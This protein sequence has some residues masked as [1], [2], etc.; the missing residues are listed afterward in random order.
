MPRRTKK[1]LEK[2]L[3]E[4]GKIYK[5]YQK[6]FDEGTYRIKNSGIY[7]LME[8]IYFEPNQDNDW[9]PKKSQDQ[10]SHSAYNLGFFAAITVECKNVVIDLD[11]KSLQQSRVF[12]LQQRFYSNIELANTPFIKGQGP[13]NFGALTGSAEHCVIKNGYLGLSSHHGI[14][15]NKVKDVTLKNLTIRDFEVAGAAINGFDSWGVNGV[16]IGPNRRDVPV[17]SGYSAGRFIHLIGRKWLE[18]NKDK[19]GDFYYEVDEKMTKLEKSLEDVLEGV[20]KGKYSE[21]NFFTMEKNS[22]DERLPDGNNYGLLAHVPGIAVLDYIEENTQAEFSKDLSLSRVRVHKIH[23]N[24]TEVVAISTLDG[25]GVQNDLSGSVFRMVDAVDKVSE[26]GIPSPDSK[27][28]PNVLSDAQ[29]YLAKASQ[30]ISEP[31]GKSTLSSELVEWALEGNDFQWLTD[32]GFKLVCN[33]D[34]MFHLQKGV[35]GVRIDA[36]RGAHFDDVRIEDVHN[37]GLLGSS[38]SGKYEKS[39]SAQKRPGYTGADVTGLSLSCA[40]EISGN[41]LFVGNIHSDNSNSRAIR[42]I[43]ESTKVK[44]EKCEIEDVS[45]GNLYS[46][47]SWYGTDSTGKKVVFS[48]TLPNLSPVAYGVC[49]EIYGD[50][51]S[52]HIKFPKIKIKGV[53]GVG[54]GSL[55]YAWLTLYD[56]S[57]KLHNSDE[58]IKHKSASSEDHVH[59][60]ECYDTSDSSSDSSWF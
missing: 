57:E 53:R 23:A 16:E 18:S 47:G 3:R 33:G 54:H 9:M 59:H 41:K 60:C 50:E 56:N 44:I 24:V 39:H 29:I 49:I 2:R 22:K 15:G 4:E 38:A 21:D 42:F 7:V 12:S 27:Y 5:L 6:D 31:I 46:E 58:N 52:K 25:A 55:D 28:K 30:K 13:G 8:D 26:S 34:S 19:L 37:F 36:M 11:G 40:H 51:P 1:S 17:N 35:H 43:N 32:Q 14:H 20:R 45:A 10:Y 48:S